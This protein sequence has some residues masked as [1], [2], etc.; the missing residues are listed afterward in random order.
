M[1][2]N[3]KK[4]TKI[5]FDEKTIKVETP[6]GIVSVVVSFYK[7]QDGRQGVQIRLFDALVIKGLWVISGEDFGP[8]V[9]LPSYKDKEGAY[10]NYVFPIDAN[11]RE[12]LFSQ[13]LRLSAFADELEDEEED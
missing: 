13:I 11:F 3:T 9:S 7:P 12:S 8:F 6:Q 2:K 5:S 1:K 4:S 10:H